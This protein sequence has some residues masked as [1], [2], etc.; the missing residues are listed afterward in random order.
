MFSRFAATPVN[1]MLPD[2]SQVWITL[3]SAQFPSLRAKQLTP[4]LPSPLKGEGL[5]WKSPRRT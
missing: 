1:Q 5:S 4:T 3:R 2:P